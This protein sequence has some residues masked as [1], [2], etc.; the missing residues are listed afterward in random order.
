M[1]EQHHELLAILGQYRSKAEPLATSQIIP[2]APL[3]AA[4]GCNTCDA[5]NQYSLSPIKMECNYLAK[6]IP[7][8]KRHI[9]R[10]FKTSYICWLK[11][12]E[13]VWSCFAAHQTPLPETCQNKCLL[14][15]VFCSCF[16]LNHAYRGERSEEIMGSEPKSIMV[17]CLLFPSRQLIDHSVKLLQFYK[18]AGSWLKLNLKFNGSFESCLPSQFQQPETQ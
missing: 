16:F 17:D 11:L 12:A 3:A 14:F 4:S 10:E 7:G 9:F 8:T 2:L 6:F 15:W 13:R 5:T 18:Q 1:A